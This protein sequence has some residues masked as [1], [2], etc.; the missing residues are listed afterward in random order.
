MQAVV[1]RNKSVIERGPQAMNIVA[2]VLAGG[3]GTRLHPLTAENAKPAVF[4]LEPV[5]KA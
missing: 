4:G 3:E 5:E 2:M 1:R